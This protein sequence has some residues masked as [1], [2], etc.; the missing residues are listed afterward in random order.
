MKQKVEQENNHFLKK[1]KKKK[2]CPQ[3]AN[4][5]SAEKRKGR[6]GERGRRRKG[7][8]VLRGEVGRVVE[9][10]IAGGGKGV[11]IAGKRKGRGRERKGRRKKR[12]GG[13]R[14]RRRRRRT[15]KISVGSLLRWIMAVGRP[16]T[17]GR[18]LL[19]R[20]RDLIFPMVLTGN[21]VAPDLGDAVKPL[22]AVQAFEILR[23]LW[24]MFGEDVLQDVLE[25]RRALVAGGVGFAQRGVARCVAG[26]MDAGAGDPV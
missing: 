3:R 5:Q 7:I 14:R 26:A 10:C 9:R 24:V 25:S 6:G 19:I 21:H 8:F 20:R 17:S 4:A 11:I 12:T 2:R 23:S 1:K 16:R 18:R 15:G 22:A 13:R